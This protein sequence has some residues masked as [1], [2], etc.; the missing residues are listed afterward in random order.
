MTASVGRRQNE[1]ILV[2]KPIRIT[3]K[4]KTAWARLVDMSA[5][6]ARI[7]WTDSTALNPR[8]SVQCEWEPV[9]GLPL[10]VEAQIVWHREKIAGLRF[11]NLSAP[12]KHYL[13]ALVRFNRR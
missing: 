8:S 10:K 5:T 2:G 11:R 12:T 7:F 13:R 9:Q 1:R 4:N 6:G 3:I